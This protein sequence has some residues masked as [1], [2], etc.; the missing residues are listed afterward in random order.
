MHMTSPGFC[1]S[2]EN[3]NVLKGHL[4]LHWED[5]INTHGGWLCLRDIYMYVDVFK[6]VNMVQG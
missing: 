5:Y 2:S 3:Y 1:L 6:N 4:G